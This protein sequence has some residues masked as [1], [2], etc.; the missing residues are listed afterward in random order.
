MM[1]PRPAD[2]LQKTYD[3]C[4]LACST[5]VYFEG[6]VSSL[7]RLPLPDAHCIRTTKTKHYG[8]GEPP[9]R[10]S[11]ITMPVE[12]RRTI[13]RN[14]KPRKPCR[15]PSGRWRCN[16]GN[17]SIYWVLYKPAGENLQMVVKRMVPM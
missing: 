2:S 4:Y 13:P 8:P 15:T 5:A 6:Q 10:L 16:A 12:Y 1:R 14:P 17:E 7:V 9:S 3:E 11:T